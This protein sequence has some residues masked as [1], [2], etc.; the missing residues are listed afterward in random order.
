MQLENRVAKKRRVISIPDHEHPWTT[1]DTSLECM[2]S[3]C[4]FICPSNY[5]IQSAQLYCLLI[6][7]KVNFTYAYF[8]EDSNEDVLN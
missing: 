1:T 7:E 2:K 5:T 8:P 4:P 3:L 6:H